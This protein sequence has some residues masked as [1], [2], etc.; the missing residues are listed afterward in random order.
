MHEVHFKPSDLILE[1][2]QEPEYVF[3]LLEGEVKV[4][5]LTLNGIHLLEYIYTNGEL[6]GEI[7]VL[8]DKPVISDVKA[9][10][11][12]RTIRV[13]KATF[14]AWMQADPEFA[15]FIARQTADKLYDACLNS[16]ANIAY[17]LKYRALYFLWNA[18]Q[19]GQAGIT[20][21]DLMNGLGSIE[22]SV[23]RI[24]NE[25]VNEG[26][27]EVERGF[28]QLT[29]ARDLLAEMRKFE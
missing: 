2:G 7:E 5:H 26:L 4:Y 12:C 20:K 6:F 29:S 3:I 18:S 22:R 1:Q 24:I 19:N 15:L 10:A 8:N 28:I 21:D 14:L 16:A 11:P 25:L 17:P 27:V 9:S 23:N 13:D